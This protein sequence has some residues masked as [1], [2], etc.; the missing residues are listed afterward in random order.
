MNREVEERIVAMYF[1]NQDFEKNAKTTIETLGQ[2]KE[3]LNLEDTA[4]KGFSVFEKIGKTLDFTKANQGLQKMKTTM[5]NMGNIFKK[6]FSLGPIDDAFRAL[7]NFK[8]KYFDRVIGFDIANKL[9][10]SMESIFRQLTV[11]PI[12][13]GWDQY[14]AK[15]DSVKTI[16]TSTG[17]SIEV[18]NSKLEEM[19]Q[20]AN[21]TIYSLTDMTSNLGKFTNNGVKLD[22]AVQAMEG[23]ANA[24]AHAGQGSQA[25]SMAMYNISQAM[26]VGKMTTVDWKSLENANVATMQ[27]KNTFLEVAAAAGKI[28]KEVVKTGDTTRTVFKL[29]TDENGKKLKKEIELTAEN[30]REYLSKGWLDKETM[31]RTFQIYSGQG[32]DENTLKSWGITDPELIKKMYELGE[33][34]M[35]AA[36]QV[37]TAGKMLDA[38]KES[39]QSGWADSFEI[40]FGNMEEGTQL[41]TRMNEKIDAI[42]S[43]STERRNKILKKWAEMTEDGR[44][45]WTTDDKG[46]K[47]RT[48]IEGGREILM[49]TFFELIDV[50]KTVGSTISEAFSKVFGKLDAKKLFDLTIGFRN[51]VNGI[52]TWLGS[53]KDANS[54]ISKLQKGLQGVFSIIKVGINFVKMIVNLAKRLF[55]PILDWAV[56]AFAAVGKFFDGLGDMRPA[57]L[58]KA[59]GNR[60]KNVW[61]D[62]TNFFKKENGQESPFET[63]AKNAW[64]GFKGIIKDWLKDVGL[65]GVWETVSG[66][67]HTIKQAFIDGWNTVSTWWNGSGIPE[68]FEGIWNTIMGWFTPK[69]ITGKQGNTWTENAPIVQFFID[70]WEG[71]QAAYEDLSKWW[72]TSGIPEFFEGIWNAVVSW[73]TP[74][75]ITGKQGNSW[76]ENAPVVQFF[77]DIWDGIQSAYNGLSKWWSTS[78][79][80]EFFEGIWNSVVSWFEPQTNEYGEVEDAPIVQF[81]VNLGDAI[82]GAFKELQTWWAGS[83]IAEFFEGIWESVV[84]WFTPKTIT[85]KMGNSWT[86]DSPIVTFFKGVWEGIKGVYDTLKEW[87]ESD[88]VQGVLQEIGG[89]FTQAWNWILSLFGE[90]TETASPQNQSGRLAN[91]MRAFGGAIS[92]VGW[93]AKEITKDSPDSSTDMEQKT[94]VFKTII[95]TI[96]QFITKIVDSIRGWVIP[97]EVQT[98]LDGFATFFSGLLDALGVLM[99]SMG[100]ILKGQG[101][102]EDFGRVIGVSIIPAVISLL[103]FFKTKWLASISAVSLAQEFLE[104][105]GGLF[106]MAS[107]VAVLTTLDE[108][109]LWGA[110]GVI[111]A[112]GVIVGLITS[113]LNGM[114]QAKA[115]TTIVLTGGQ[116]ILTTLINTIGRIG[117]IATVLGMLPT[118]IETIGKVKKNIGDV[119]I[120]TDLL[121]ILLAITA[122]ISGVSI[123]L[124]ATQAISGK[125]GIDPIAAVKT[126]IAVMAAL[127]VVIG[128][129]AGIVALTNKFVGGDPQKTIQDVNDAAGVLAAVGGAIGSFFAALFGGGTG[130]QKAGEVE[131]TAEK[132]DEMAQIFDEE[133]VT[134]INRM[135]RLMESVTE[136]ASKVNAVELGNFGLMMGY[137]GEGIYN[138]ASKLAEANGPLAEI[139]DTGSDMYKRLVNFMSIVGMI[140]D[141]AGEFGSKSF[142]VEA[143]IANI[144]RLAEDLT[145]GME[146]GWV[147]IGD[148]IFSTSS[149][150]KATGEGFGTLTNSWLDNLHKIMTRLG[151]EDWTKDSGIQFDGLNIANKLVQ[152][153]QEGLLDPHV[154]KFDATPITTAILDALKLEDKAIAEVVHNMVQNGLVISGQEGFST[155]NSGIDFLN[156]WAENGGSTEGLFDMSGLTEMLTGK[157]GKGGILG[158]LNGLADKIPS[159]GSMFADKGWMDFKDENGNEIDILSELQG[160][161]TELGTTLDTMEP[162]KVTI[163]PVVDFS[164]ITPE[165]LQE[166]LNGKPV[167]LNSIFNLPSEGLKIDFTGLDSALD[168]A[169]VLLRLQGIIDQMNASTITLGED[170]DA[171]GGHMESIATEVSRLQ[172]VLDTGALVG[173]I[174]P[175]VDRELDSL[176]MATER[177]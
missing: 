170:I 17:E 117:M 56:N 166:Q 39:V 51:L 73:F 4:Q 78:G 148:D 101:S 55:G 121:N 85:G 43:A 90:E 104:I 65:E 29:T 21:K 46:N 34:A 44:N 27:L 70:I 168:M 156:K 175:M 173:Q 126:A 52:K 32:I 142:D 47:V 36:T 94:S 137:F 24:T 41:W 83:G 111:A 19:T 6:I 91:R 26:G 163:T 141:M 18:V 9:V 151:E 81:F 5:S 82:D 42:L 157:D 63:W 50:A 122:L 54:R 33:E 135:I 127:A 162:L 107:G 30:F 140:G 40:I 89:F 123:A 171:L 67:W 10:S 37:R 124:A 88:E 155:D 113:T 165:K 69:T 118:I 75:T 23:I 130:A 154:K 59:L 95:D 136:T 159:L 64:N 12:S 125:A 86:E 1:D 7:D 100:N 150:Y 3:G 16:M 31:L 72:S 132:L 49:N 93:T 138:I 77:L 119:D 115:A 145:Y 58:F 15:M 133:K 152:S 74:K 146:G 48:G 158:E 57:Y 99:G 116:Q 76:T 14:Q 144:N 139:G 147:K 176:A 68:F 53:T 38:L 174:T 2:L 106:L 60:L 71:M 84:G 20:Y 62:I 103:D 105:S 102:L 8:N 112:L 161:L 22:D 80:P 108:S 11:Q 45:Y 28:K 143:M 66:W 114:A 92:D 87:W 109:K 98:F 167:E 177:Q 79:I 149:G 13:A 131:R 172:L 169:T 120:G 129:M 164:Q 61:K 97:P 35:E 25:A 153:I 134:G 96:T 110:V 128:A 160:H